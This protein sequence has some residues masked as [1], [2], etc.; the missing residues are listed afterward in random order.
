VWL[1]PNSDWRSSYHSWPAYHKLE[2]VERLMHEIRTVT[3]RVRAR[4]HVE[5]LEDNTRTLGEHYRLKLA[6]YRKYRASAADQL[7]LRVFTAAPTRVTRA[8]GKLKDR[9]TRASALLR[10][11]RRELVVAV[12]RE[13][14]VDHYNVYQIL[15]LSIERSDRLALCVRGSKREALRNA[16]WMLARLVR[17]Y[18]QGAT[19]H[20][21]L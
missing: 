3:P 12:A 7:L 20:L 2:F 14:A 5:P 19:P 9:K 6:R 4:A 18:G 15:R 21:S 1:K 11:S 17:L 13:T 16:R 8:T 10:A